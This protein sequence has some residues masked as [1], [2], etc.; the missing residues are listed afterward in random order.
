MSRTKDVLRAEGLDCLLV[1]DVKNIFYLTGFLDISSA[2]LNML[3]QPDKESLLF[4]TSLSKEAATSQAKDCVVEALEVGESMNERLVKALKD[5]KIRSLGYDFLNLQ[6][7]LALK[8]DLSAELS[9]RAEVITRQ[10]RTKDD[11]EVSLISRACEIADAGMKA[12]I[13]S[14]RPGATEYEVAA[15][16]EYAMRKHG[17]AGTAFETLVASGPRSAFPHGVSGERAV[18]DGELVTVD[19]GATWRGYCSDITRTVIVGKPSAKDTRM[20]R[21]VKEAHDIV[22]KELHAGVEG[23]KMDTLARTALGPSLKPYFVHGL[24]HGVGLNIHEAPTLSQSS[25]DVLEAGNVVTDE[26][27]VYIHGHGGVRTEDTVLVLKDGCRK[28]TSSPYQ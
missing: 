21:K 5:S 8:K 27:G 1:T 25:K 16:A 2:T 13:E 23:A 9:D 17:S 20:M 14:I 22:L 28:L 6:T 19:L 24:G 11:E 3:V 4:V 15:E 12:A 18:R 7:Y 10:R 26:P